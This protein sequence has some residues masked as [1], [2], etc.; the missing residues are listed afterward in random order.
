MRFPSSNIPFSISGSGSRATANPL[1]LSEN[2][3]ENV[4]IVLNF[5]MSNLGQKRADIDFNSL[6]N[7]F[8]NPNVAKALLTSALRCFSFESPEILK[9]LT[10]KEN[11][12]VKKTKNKNLSGFLDSE[13]E[14]LNISKMSPSQI[15]NFIFTEVN[16]KY[17]GFVPPN[18]RES[19][20][21]EIA[22]T[23]SLPEQMLEV[24]MYMDLESEKILQKKCELSAIDLIKYYNYD[25]IYTLLAMSQE[26]EINV[27]NMSGSTIKKLIVISKVNYVFTEIQKNN[28]TFSLHV[29]PPLELISKGKWG[30][31]IAKV[32]TYIIRSALREKTE[33]ELLAILQ[34][35]NR[36]IL[37]PLST[38]HLPLLPI[39]K[40]DDEIFEKPEI[41]SKI[42]SKFY[43]TWKMMHGWKAIPEPEA[44]IVGNRVIIPDFL[45]KRGKTEVYVEIVGY[46][47]HQYI[48]KKKNVMTLLAR[49][50][51]P[52]I[53]LIDEQ[54]RPH[55]IDL[56]NIHAVYYSKNEVPTKELL[57]LLEE[58][59]TDYEERVP[60]LL[61]KLDKICNKLTQNGALTLQQLE[62][63][64]ETYSRN[65]LL[66]ILQTPEAQQIFTEHGI[67]FIKSFG[68]VHNQVIE[69]IRQFLTK[70]RKIEYAVLKQQFPEYGEAIVPIC[71][72]LG[73]QLRWKSF[74]DILIIAP[75]NLKQEKDENNTAV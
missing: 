41:D 62:T 34:Y 32:V 61:G 15:R 39:H 49:N 2:D 35:R 18:E 37:F 54:L 60:V 43:N 58:N 70:H 36:K 16:K 55:F 64:I 68:L 47:T 53:Y 48:Q 31:N 5:L 50:N 3:I 69:D 44:I 25:L 59:Y 26:V 52:I 45:L 7:L 33:F 23:L 57:T 73:A 8:S 51:V 24:V 12:K 9:G 56:R 40:K 20:V 27:K 29:E 4:E 72:Y 67:T 17:S 22:D 75:R 65:E 19:F 71:Q 63:Q 21:K 38:H 14:V 13:G 10:Q 6:N 30:E 66:R 28:G 42:E 74:Q 11:N 46:Y 1:F